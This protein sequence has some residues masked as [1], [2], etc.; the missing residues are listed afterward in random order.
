MSAPRRIAHRHQP[1]YRVVRAGWKDPLDASF[2]QRAPDN[3]WNGPA[4]PVLY[5]C[6]SVR[7]ARAI[8]RDLFALA[9]VELAELQP[10]YRPALV[11]IG[12]R[13]E[14]IDVASP[15]GVE[16]AG[17]PESYPEGVS[18]VQTRKAAALWHGQGA[19]GILCRS[20]SLWRRG[21]SEWRG[22]HPPWAELALF[23]ENCH[24]WPRLRS[25]R[26]ATEWSV[27]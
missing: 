7:V 3:R 1:F 22:P 13:G 25:R 10:A 21:F 16:A 9:G 2:S 17:L 19:E 12:W 26:Q 14:V 20:A 15:Q 27:L 23:V 4:Y 6:C 18:R 24:R 5:C 11:E 8:V